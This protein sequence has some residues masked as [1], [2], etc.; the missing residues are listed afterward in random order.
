MPLATKI[1]GYSA[2]VSGNSTLSSS[3]ESD[4][5]SESD[6]GR[7][8]RR[9][10]RRRRPFINVEEALKSIHSSIKSD[11][12]S[13]PCFALLDTNVYLKDGTTLVNLL[14]AETVGPFVV[15]GRLDLEV[16][17]EYYS[18]CMLCTCST[19]PLLQSWIT[20]S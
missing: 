10:R 2:L 18:Y 5:G 13:W 3:T 7:D 9:S 12:N 4:S 14:E 20:S 6:S 16:E 17:D 8:G 15:T 19:N 1:A 11:S